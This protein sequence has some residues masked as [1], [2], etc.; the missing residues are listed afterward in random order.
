[1]IDFIFKTIIFN[2][3]NVLILF[4]IGI[5]YDMSYYNK[6]SCFSSWGY[7]FI[8]FYH[9]CDKY[10]G[11]KYKLSA[12]LFNLTTIR[13]WLIPYFIILFGHIY[14][15]CAAYLITAFYLAV[16]EKLFFKG[17]IFRISKERI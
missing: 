2:I 3:T 16:L 7:L 15:Q 4:L 10:K 17:F 8:H 12:S 9:F 11:K 1:M 13:Y 5:F 14:F 6:Y